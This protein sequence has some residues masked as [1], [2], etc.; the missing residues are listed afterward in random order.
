MGRKMA[1]KKNNR[2]KMMR[3]PAIL[4]GGMAAVTVISL[5]CAFEGNP[6]EF[7]AV[8]A[9]N[10]WDKL[11][12]VRSLGGKAGGELTLSEDGYFELYTAADYETFWKKAQYWHDIKGRMMNDIYLNDTADISAWYDE[13]PE[14]VSEPV[15]YFSGIFDGNG[16]TIYGL[17]SES[18]CGLVR[19]NMG[20]IINLS[21]R[22][23]LVTGQFS[24]GA[25]GGLCYNNS[26]LISGCDFGGGVWTIMSGKRAGICIEN[27]GVIEKCGFTGTMRTSWSRSDKAGICVK[28][29][30]I[31]KD[32]YNLSARD[33]D[34]YGTCYA[35][36]NAGESNCYV[37]RGAGWEIFPE[38]QVIEL[39]ENQVFYIED[40]I[41]NNFYP[42]YQSSKN[43]AVWLCQLKNMQENLKAAGKKE[44]E[45]G[46]VLLGAEENQNRE[47]EQET[48]I[49]LRGNEGPEEEQDKIAREAALK[50]A[51]SDDM[52]TYMIRQLTGPEKARLDELSF[53]ASETPGQS[54][55]F[56]IELMWEGDAVEIAAFPAKDMKENLKNLWRMCGDILRVSNS[57]GWEHR[58][59]KLSDFE[60]EKKVTK[61]AEQ[62]QQEKSWD[63]E[64]LLVIYKTEDGR[65]G[66]FY[67]TDEKAYLITPADREDTVLY[68]AAFWK[69]YRKKIITEGI[70][71]T[72]EK[73]RRA[74]LEA[75]GAGNSME[76]EPVSSEEIMEL[77]NLTIDHAQRIDSF[78]DLK[79]LPKLSSLAIFCDGTTDDQ[80]TITID[81]EKD[82]LSELK[83]LSLENCKLENMNFTSRLSGLERLTMKACSCEGEDGSFLAN[84]PK[85]SALELDGFGKLNP[86]CLKN[87]GE[88]VRLSLEGNSIEDISSLASLDKLK[89]LSLADNDI[90]D[91]SVLRRLSELES[92]D[93]SD[94]Q[95]R[96]IDELEALGHLNYLNLANNQIRDIDSLEKLQEL[97]WLRVDGNQITD[98]SAVLERDGIAVRY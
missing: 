80:N 10:G 6:A 11:T 26:A 53:K 43:E 64:A 29:S 1:K 97:L 4:L 52:V 40:L 24:V 88:L 32:C 82:A 34:L 33:E 47:K 3:K 86:S 69:I 65:E 25:V 58:T 96:E 55:S 75:L 93:L 16:H 12:D 48:A 18:R 68:E 72:D 35:I 77:T 57:G 95:V 67:I 19:T 2:K 84:M 39:P 94:N 14:N 9:E 71:W 27:S 76:E 22:E 79:Y 87:L 91:I 17:Y 54:G 60:E 30:G 83:E 89:G 21:V 50:K 8:M 98:M 41:D 46:I 49:N 51:L 74:V 92:L 20:S 44:R 70:S 23:S 36:A 78:R 13:A 56:Q 59:Y 31:I 63:Q 37:R 66:F 90:E 61:A 38:N 15:N 45:Q 28:N 5:F 85:L 81:I 42:L 62:Y 73:I 7:I